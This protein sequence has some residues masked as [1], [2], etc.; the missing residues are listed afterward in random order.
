[1]SLIELPLSRD[2]IDGP[3]IGAAVRAMTLA[4]H[5]M[6]V[7]LTAI[8]VIGA[9]NDRTPAPVAIGLGLA[10][11]TWHE[12]GAVLAAR[13]RVPGAVAWWLGGLTLIWIGAVAVSTQF[14]WLAFLLWLLAGH[15]LPLRWG[16]SYSVLVLVVVVA[17]PVLDHGTTTAANVLGPAI[18]GVFAFGISR[19]YLRLL[20]DATERER[21]VASLRRAQQESA[22]LQDELAL[23][24]RHS[25]VIAE[26]TRIARDVHDTVAQSLSSIRLL[27]H[28]E[29]PATH[30]ARE[31][32]ALRQ[33][34]RLASESL[35]DVRRILAALVPTQLEDDALAVALTRMLERVREETG[36]STAVHVD[37]SLPLLTTEVE[38]ALLRT[39][40][41]ALANVRQHAAASRIAVSVIDAGDSV[42]LDI[43]DDGTGFDVDAWEESTHA[44]SSSFG[45]GFV[46]SRVRELGGELDVESSPAG[47]VVSVRLPIA[48]TS[49]RSS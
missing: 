37:D 13:S 28:A 17:A 40:Q 38:V 23:A 10:L 25:G 1:M 2:E 15:L 36:L 43:V 39:A 42:R 35:A 49:P 29:L 26:R 18:G 41:S 31:A 44:P 30:E 32:R 45:L 20:Q 47:T 46:R 27:A 9:I 14:V 21:L 24:Q 22:D 48:S 3:T 12:V 33:I 34:E 11:L 8:G 16:L 4:Q 5:V 6:A 19:G 7:A